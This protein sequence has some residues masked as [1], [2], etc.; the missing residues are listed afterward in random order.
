MQVEVDRV[1]LRLRRSKTDHQGKG[2]DVS[3]FAL[4]G[5]RVCPVEAVR[6]FPKIRTDGA[7]PFLRHEDGYYLSKFQ[8]ISIFRKCHKAAGLDRAGYTSHSFRIGAATEAAR[9]GLDEAAVRRIGRWDLRRFRSY[10]RPHL[11]VE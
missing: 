5:S 6:E 1:C 4:P 10:I 9:C 7:G 2:V 11:A 3:L 8:F